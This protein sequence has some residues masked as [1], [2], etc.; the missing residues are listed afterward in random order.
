M[1]VVSFC[2][3]LIKS[4]LSFMNSKTNQSKRSLLFIT[5]SHLFTLQYFQKY[6]GGLPIILQLI[7]HLPTHPG[8]PATIKLAHRQIRIILG[9]QLLLHL[10]THL[11]IIDRQPN[12]C[13]V[14]NT[15]LIAGDHVSVPDLGHELGT[16]HYGFVVVVVDF[17]RAESF[18]VLYALLAAHVGGA[19]AGTGPEVLLVD[20]VAAKIACDGGTDHLYKRNTLRRCTCPK[21]R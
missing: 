12:A 19:V 16:V 17:I 3:L 11:I 10:Q 8:K 15:P 7:I 14:P 1:I 9:S 21:C 5:K 6:L 2:I 13:H 18:H 20:A 4:D